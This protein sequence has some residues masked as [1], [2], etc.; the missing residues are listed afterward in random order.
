MNRVG[1][2]DRIADRDRDLE[3]LNR[4]AFLKHIS[5]TIFAVCLASMTVACTSGEDDGEND[6]EDGEDEEDKD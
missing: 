3:A 5:E 6:D 4:R 2:H 1:L